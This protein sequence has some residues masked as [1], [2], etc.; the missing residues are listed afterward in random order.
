[1]RTA[2]QE[3][4]VFLDAATDPSWGFAPRAGTCLGSSRGQLPGQEARSPRRHPS[5]SAD[6]RRWSLR[7][8]A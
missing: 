2:G 5:K 1:M 6:G 8:P 7:D 4:R 3:A